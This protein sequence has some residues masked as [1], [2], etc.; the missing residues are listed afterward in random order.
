[1]SGETVDRKGYGSS[2]IRAA[3]RP[4]STSAMASFTW[5]SGPVSPITRVLRR[6]AAPLVCACRPSPWTMGHSTTLVVADFGTVRTRHDRRSRH[7]SAPVGRNVGRLPGGRQEVVKRLVNLLAGEPLLHPRVHLERCSR[8]LVTDLP[9]DVWE[10][11]SRLGQQAE[12]ERSDGRI[13][14]AVGQSCATEN[15]KPQSV[16]HSDDRLCNT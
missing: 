8:V 6:G 13:V 14:V 3:T 2:T 5:S 12:R 10:R 9:Q 15:D 16:G 4:A 7:L 1:M 11:S